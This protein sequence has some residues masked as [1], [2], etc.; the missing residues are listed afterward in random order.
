MKRE[1]LENLG[2]DKET[3]DKIMS[4]NGADIER[5]KAKATQAKADLA[6]AQKQLA[7]RD[8]DLEQL[9]ST[10]GDAEASKKA[11]EELQ[12]KYS[13]ETEQLKAQIAERDYSDAINRDIAEKIPN[14]F[15]GGEFTRSGFIAALR[16]KHKE[17]KDGHVVG[18][19]DFLKEQKETRPDAF[20]PDNPPPRIVAPNGQQNYD[21]TPANIMQARKMGEARAASA[22]ASEDV[23][24]NYL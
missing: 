15:Q 14:G 22:K 10:A 20:A 2:L 17:H 1:F 18:F 21:H 7:D 12:A 3:V 13:A 5:E 11:L 23:M 4:E 6:D 19:D 8:K 24:K 9:K 16:E